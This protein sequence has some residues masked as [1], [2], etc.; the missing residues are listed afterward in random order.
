[1]ASDKKHEDA[2]FFRLMTKTTQIH[3]HSGDRIKG[4]F[5]KAFDHQLKL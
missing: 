3:E 2:H 5:W 4:D 1:M